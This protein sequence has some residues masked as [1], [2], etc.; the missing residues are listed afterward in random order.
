MQTDNYKAVKQTDSTK[1]M[2]IKSGD[3]TAQLCVCGT[4][5]TFI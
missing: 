5:T 4:C 1:T 2:K 3:N